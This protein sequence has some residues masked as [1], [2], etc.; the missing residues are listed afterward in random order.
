MKDK[1]TLVH[2]THEAAGKI[3]GI[4]AVLEGF[5]T[6][7]P[8][9]DNVART[10]LVC[11]LFTTDGQCHDR[12]GPGGE[13]LYS[14]IDGLINNTY[15]RH[16]KS[17]QEEFNVEIVYGKKTFAH[18][19][20]GI[21]S[22][23]EVILIDVTRMDAEPLNKFKKRLFEEFG[24]RSDLYEHFWDYEEYT[25]L[26]M[27][28]I[29]ALKAIGAAGHGGGAVI[30]SHEY[31]G[32]PT[33]LAGIL[34]RCC[35]FKTVFHA[36]E[37]ATI[38]KIVEEHPGHDTMFRNVLKK[39]HQ[40]GLYV[41]D[42]FGDQMSF[43]KHALIDASK[44]CDNI[45]AVGDGIVEELRF[46]A[47]QF[48]LANIDLVY[49]GIPAYRITLEE[50]LTSKE[51]LINYAE[52]LVG[53]RPDF[54]FT[55]VTRMTPSKGLW[56][57]LRVL[58]HMEKELAALGKTAV[59]FVL[60]TQVSQRKKS[61]ILK[62]EAGY[63]WPVAHRE[64]MPDLSEGEAAFYCGVQEFNTKNRNIKVIYINQFGF[65]RDTCGSRMPANIEFMDI[66]KGTDVE[67]GQSIYEPFGIAQL[68]SLSFGGICVVT[69]VCGCTGFVRDVTN[70]K[71]TKNV[72][73]ADYTDLSCHRY[74]DIDDLVHIDRN[75]RNN[76]ESHISE[77]VA[78]E[79]CARLPKN[80]QE[81]EEMIRSGYDLAKHMN[82]NVVV[83]N[84]LLNSL[85]KAVYRKKFEQMC[86][87]V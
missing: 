22:S 46:L 31:M 62:M 67:F 72:I 54:I 47:P 26:A 79:I 20:T 49:N 27:P 78:L 64:G 3:G 60:S 63:N 23:P 87:R 80:E 65:S 7:Q 16:F 41:S 4:G 75:S 43:F 74:E 38:R 36:H 66:R 19:R 37:V 57:D 10:V 44:Y 11:P 35:D 45:I 21:K 51:K 56:R 69:N 1:M 42:I 73:I 52:S 53:H 76:I 50:K 29:A 83:Q 85:E 71:D 25:R 28:A 9:I 81:I 32:M 30:I 70:G 61:D 12:L 68:E 39:A 13:V 34:D 15:A 17:I 59:F 40:Q 77:K 33:V 86:V 82:W 14:S 58:E 55:H 48:E 8:Y 5:F 18:H 84:Y 24:I 2:V 6:S